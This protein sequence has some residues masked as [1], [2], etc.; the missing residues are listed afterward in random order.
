MLQRDRVKAPILI[1]F[2]LVLLLVVS[3]LLATAY[4]YEDRARR[5]D[6]AAGRLAAEYMLAAEIESHAEI[7]RAA[8]LLLGLDGSLSAA[9]ESGDRERLLAVVAPLFGQMRDR[10][11]LSH[12]YLVD[13]SRSVVLRA[14]RPDLHDDVIERAS[15]R[16]GRKPGARP[17]APKPGV[18]GTSPCVSWSLGMTASV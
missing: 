3:A 15:M 9:F 13:T 14:H 5:Q 17:T 7:L 4:W 8:L 12:F 2:G 18:W 6:L 10:L 16:G 1:P 11:G